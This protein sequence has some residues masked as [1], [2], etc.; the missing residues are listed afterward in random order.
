MIDP[1]FTKVKR[2]FV[3]SFEKENNRTSFSKYYVSNVQIKEFNMLIDGNLSFDIPIKTGEETYEQVIEMARNNDYT[4]GNLLDYVY[5][6]KQYQ[7]IAKDLSKQTE[8]ENSDLKHQI[9]FIRRLKRDE[10]A[11]MFFIIE[12]SEETTFQFS[13]NAVTVA[14]FWL[15]IK[16]ETQK[17]ANLLSDADNESSKFGTRKWYVINDQNNTDY[18]EGN[19]DSTTVKFETKVI[20]SNLCDYSDAYILVTGNITATGLGSNTRVPFKN[21]PPFTKCITH[22]ND[23][24]VDNADNLGIIMPMYNLIEYSDNYS[25]TSGSLWQLKRDEQNMSNVNPAKYKST[26]FKPLTAD[27]NRLFKDV[28][29]V[30]PLKYLSNFWRSLEMLLISCKIH[31]ELNWSKDCIM[32]TIADTTFKITNTKLYVPIVTLSSKDNVKLVKLLEEG[33]KRPVYWNE[34]QTKIET[35]DLDNNNLTRFPLDASF[36]GVRRL[37]ALA[38]NNTTVNVP[39]NPINNTNNRVLKNSHAKY[40]L[41]RAN[42]SNYNVLIDGR[43]LCDQPNNDLIK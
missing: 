12:K 30:V 1:T 43:N 20:K 29:I 24:H 40:F 8:L 17:I 16:M 33:F 14:W 5:F 32:S 27:D 36:K 34:Y 35:R 31:L 25:G 41:P 3:L 42:I 23:E 19:E 4:T 39:N 21:C 26:F 2:L 13:Q 10:V 22:I 9:N 38:F 6:S 11:T 18:G 28:K 7:L 15:R 37:F